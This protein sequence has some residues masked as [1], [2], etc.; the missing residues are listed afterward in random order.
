MSVCLFTCLSHSRNWSFKLMW[1]RQLFNLLYFP[2]SGSKGGC[3]IR[4]VCTLPNQP[5]PGE[6]C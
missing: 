2:G 1:N 6:R 5:G 4:K 3:T